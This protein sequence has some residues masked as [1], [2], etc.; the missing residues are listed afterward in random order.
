MDVSV[1]IVNYNTLQLTRDCLNSIIEHT[2]DL[3]YEV[4][5]VDNDSIDGSSETLAFEFPQFLTLKSTENIGFGK[6]N[7]LGIKQAKG[8]YLFL[9]N[10]DTVLLNDAINIFYDFAENNKQIKIGAL[11]CELLNRN[12]TIGRSSSPLPSLKKI[13][14]DSL[15]GYYSRIVLRKPTSFLQ[16]LI[17][18][19]QEYMPVGQITGADLFIPH[20]VI[21]QIGVFDPRFF[22]YFEETDL[23]KRMELMGFKRLLIKGPKIIHFEGQSNISIKKYKMYYKSMFQY[24]MKHKLYLPKTL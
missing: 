19:K 23:Q 24:I 12:L 6:G 8:K 13:I 5:I 2:R 22:M 15:K 18:K 17:P 16:Q 14:K 9:L 21:K 20:S 11:G 4:I 7:N 1:I 10:S 3:K